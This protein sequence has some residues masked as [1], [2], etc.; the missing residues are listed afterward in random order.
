VESAI[1]GLL[2][3]IDEQRAIRRLQ[4]MVRIPAVAGEERPMAEYVA[5]ALR[6]SG[7]DS[8]HVD[9]FWNVLG[10]LGN[11]SGPALL[12]LTH[13]D[14]APAGNMANAYSGEVMD[15]SRFGK[16]GRVVFGRGACA[17][18][19]AVAAIIEAVAALRDARVSLGGKLLVAAVT[20]DLRANHE[21]VKEMVQSHPLKARYCLAGE[22]SDNHVVLG[23]RGIG[24]FEIRLKGV[25]AHW[26][27][28]A[29]AANPLYGMADVLGRLEGLT[30]PTHPV[31]GTATVSPYEVRAD[32]I[33]PRSPE[34]AVI[35]LDR[36]LLPEESPED[37]RQ[38]LARL[39]SE[40]IAGRPKLSA[41]VTYLRGMYPYSVNADSPAVQL[42]QQAGQAVFQRSLPTTYITF[43][44]NAAYV[45]REIGIDGV[46]F[47][48]GRI[49]DV[50]ETEH[51]E[52]AGV[53]D[54][55]RVYGA[56]AV[57]T[58]GVQ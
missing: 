37:V 13:T 12:L 32:A 10:T 18:K 36:R 49:G 53:L 43:S 24:H 28:P 7:C 8:I 47:G 31:L 38:Q 33:P 42:V 46:C 25:S 34:S 11:S 5:G 45:I 29:E 6:E 3:H 40:A 22:P 23:A 58:A 19:A 50:T 2:N 51:V 57:L 15:G 17:P 48:P 52:V 30:L 39:V 35:V 14:S 26:G 55:A 16:T 56:A 4:E 44:S 54:A 9:Q 1:Q 21:G 27:R 41:E 20:K